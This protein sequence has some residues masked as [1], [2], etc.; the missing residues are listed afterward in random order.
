V[1]AAVQ[2]QTSS[3]AVTGPAGVQV[4]C[5]RVLHQHTHHGAERMRQFDL[6]PVSGLPEHTCA[7]M[8]GRLWASVRAGSPQCLSWLRQGPGV[9]AWHAGARGGDFADQTCT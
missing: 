1:N 8:Q 3:Q 4:E 9:H 2:R 5:R 7:T 6:K